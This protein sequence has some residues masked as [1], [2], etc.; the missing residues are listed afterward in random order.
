MIIPDADP[1]QRKAGDEGCV[2]F[3]ANATRSLPAIRDP[4]VTRYQRAAL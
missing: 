4:F 2:R 3:T 1:R